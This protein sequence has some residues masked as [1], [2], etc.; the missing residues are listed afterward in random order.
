MYLIV[1][2]GNPGKKFKESRHNI[3]FMALDFFV[4]DKEKWHYCK[5]GKYLWVKKQINGKEVELIKPQTFMNNSG[6]AVASAQKKIKVAI[7]NILVVLDDM[8]LPLGTI[9]IRKK[10]SSGGHKGLQSIIDYLKTEEIP[11][12][13][14][15]I[16]RSEKIDPQKW[17][18]QK[19]TKEEKI[20]V[21]EVL[22]QTK[23]ILLQI[24]KEGIEKHLGTYKI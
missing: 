17:V 14:I 13:R 10:G 20:K 11:R 23:K 5:V 21:K 4:G 7:E 8:D 15:G 16:G 22:S 2:L 6:F 19:F 12:C 9:R 1:G 3:G 18:L 24:I